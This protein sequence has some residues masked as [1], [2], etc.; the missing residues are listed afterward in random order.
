MRSCSLTVSCS[1]TSRTKPFSS[2]WKSSHARWNSRSRRIAADAC[3]CFSL[4]AVRSCV[5]LCASR[6]FAA[7]ASGIESAECGRSRTCGAAREEGTAEEPTEHSEPRRSPEPNGEGA[8]EPGSGDAI[9]DCWRGVWRGVWPGVGAASSSLSWS[10]EWTRAR[11][12]AADL[13]R[14]HRGSDHI[15]WYEPD[16]GRIGTRRTWSIAGC[17]R[18]KMSDVPVSPASFSSRIVSMRSAPRFPCG[19]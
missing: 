12:T 6:I 10:E 13:G 8:T 18:T 5:A 2:D 3:A 15:F 7:R 19:W 14:V 4:S 1:S 9:A 16:A 17:G 11:C